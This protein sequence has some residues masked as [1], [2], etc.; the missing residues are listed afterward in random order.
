M[1]NYS[2]DGAFVIFCM[3]LARCFQIFVLQVWFFFAR[4]RYILCVTG[5]SDMW[6]GWRCL[7]VFL[8]SFVSGYGLPVTQ[9]QITVSIIKHTHPAHDMLGIYSHLR[10][11]AHLA[12]I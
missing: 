5:S 7:M 2:V 6:F 9:S 1:N 11:R 8:F 12:I 3:H 4:G 10:V